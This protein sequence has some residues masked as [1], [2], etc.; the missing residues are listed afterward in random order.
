M[1]WLEIGCE[2]IFEIFE[3]GVVLVDVLVVFECKFVNDWEVV[4]FIEVLMI[5]F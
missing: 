5:L 1:C 3:L 4:E 2:V